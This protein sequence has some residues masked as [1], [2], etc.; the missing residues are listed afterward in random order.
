MLTAACSA[1]SSSRQELLTDAQS[2]LSDLLA[3]PLE[4][5]AG[6]EEFAAIKDDNFKE[7][8]DAV[9]EGYESG[10]LAAAMAAGPEGFKVRRGPA[11]RRP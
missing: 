8:V 6:S 3:Y 4:E 11:G 5:T 7:V 2:V 10:A 1:P 9:V